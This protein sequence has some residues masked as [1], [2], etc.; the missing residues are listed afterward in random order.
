[1]RT[2]FETTQGLDAAQ[3]GIEVRGL[4]ALTSENV[5]IS[6]CQFTQLSIGVYSIYDT[7]TITIKDSFFF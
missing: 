6:N 2:R 7:Q 3:S 4:G 5:T 1:M